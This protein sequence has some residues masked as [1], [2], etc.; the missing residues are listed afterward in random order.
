MPVDGKIILKI[1]GLSMKHKSCNQA[2][3]I[4]PIRGKKSQKDITVRLTQ[5]RYIPKI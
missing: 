3:G 5:N 4:P 2:Q 1:G